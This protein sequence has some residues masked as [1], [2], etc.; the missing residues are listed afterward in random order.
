MARGVWVTVRAD[1]E[2]GLGPDLGFVNQAEE[3][4]KAELL[5]PKQTEAKES[6][7]ICRE[8]VIYAYSIG[9]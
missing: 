8:K 9:M 4:T 7:S 1:E 2:D 6:H 3:L 5:W